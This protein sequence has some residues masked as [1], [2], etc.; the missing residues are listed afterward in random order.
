MFFAAACPNE[1]HIR[2]STYGKT[3]MSPRQYT[4]YIRQA[5][6]CTLPEKPAERVVCQIS[7]TNIRLARRFCHSALPAR[8]RHR[9]DPQLAAEVRLAQ[10]ALLTEAFNFGRPFGR[11]DLGFSGTSQG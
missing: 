9:G 11:G 8:N 1:A 6:T 10:L 4:H 7:Q 2:N 5:K 3:P